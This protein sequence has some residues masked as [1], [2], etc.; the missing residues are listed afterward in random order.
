MPR[1]RR[2]LKKGVMRMPWRHNGKGYGDGELSHMGALGWGVLHY[3][4]SI[5]VEEF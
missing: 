1:E 5:W 2:R 4:K 3:D